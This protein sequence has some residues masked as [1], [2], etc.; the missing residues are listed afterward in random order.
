MLCGCRF[1][2]VQL[3]SAALLCTLVPIKLPATTAAR[4]SLPNELERLKQFISN[5]FLAL[6]LCYLSLDV[7]GRHGI[8]S[9]DR[10]L[11]L[12]G[13]EMRRA[14]L[15]ETPELCRTGPH[16]WMHTP[17]PRSDPR[18]QAQDTLCLCCASA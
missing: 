6:M 16:S 7:S 17:G 1:L 4:S 15:L 8:K 10:E 5:V 3:S 13:R 18:M 11:S 9:T 12:G 14:K 2:L